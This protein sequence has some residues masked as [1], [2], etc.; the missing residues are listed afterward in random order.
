[1]YCRKCGKE[2]KDNSKF[3]PYCGNKMLMAQSSPPAPAQSELNADTGTHST[4]ERKEPPTDK[5]KVAS[6]PP[7]PAKPEL[8][9]DTGTHSTA[10]RKEPPTD[11]KKVASRPKW[12]IPVAVVSSVAVIGVAVYMGVKVMHKPAETTEQVTADIQ[13]QEEKPVGS[14]EP[15][16]SVESAEPQEPEYPVDI[17]L[18]ED[19]MKGIT[20]LLTIMGNI[21]IMGDERFTKKKELDD[22]VVHL[23]VMQVID[24]N[25][26]IR[27]SRVIDVNSEGY[28]CDSEWTIP[29]DVLD[30]Y[31]K[32]SINYEEYKLW[33]WD[34]YSDGNV[35]LAVVGPNSVR[36]S[37]TPQISKVEQVSAD[38]IEV[39]GT[40]N[41]VDD[42]DE[43]LAYTAEFDVI[44]KKNP[45][46]MWGGYTLTEIKS[47]GRQDAQN[48]QNA[49]GTTG[50]YILPDITNR[51]YSE[52]ELSGMDANTLSLARNEL[53]A[54]HGYI[55]KKPELQ[56]YFG[57]KS[58]YTP[59]VSEVPD[60][61]FNEYEK[62]N[63]E[64]IQKLEANFK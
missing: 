7:V 19:E 11:K 12:V 2:I 36:F 51:Y 60:S 35:K 4:A 10:E 28:D 16:E 3:C 20:D 31:I 8:N 62:A 50:D 61:A 41:Y 46:S 33:N 25:I 34:T 54:R 21:D 9:S 30:K 37:K 55:F 27:E 64:L 44:M 40:V 29:K 45:D 23:F 63:L 52:N 17:T 57:G 32:D 1:M 43:I 38:E 26:S 53:Y 42:V 6:R 58:W 47:W 24:R 56:E 18:N 39:W 5:K 49:T 15:V 13:K 48:A 59:Q 14:E 22:D